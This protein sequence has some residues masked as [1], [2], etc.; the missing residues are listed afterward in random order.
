VKKVIRGHE[1]FIE[2]LS[3]NIS[4][5]RRNSYSREYLLEENKNVK[6]KYQNDLDTVNR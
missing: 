2:E 1:G 5:L 6:I 3:T 4:L